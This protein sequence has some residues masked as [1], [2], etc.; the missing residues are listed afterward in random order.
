M[1]YLSH[2]FFSTRTPMSLTG[3]LMG[4]FKPD[5][6]LRAKLPAEVLLGIDNHRLVD[7]ATDKFLP[8]KE[9]RPLFSQERRRY[10][11][12]I[13]DI[14]FDYFLIKH[15]QRFGQVEFDT[16]IDECY[17]GL[18]QCMHWMPPRMHYVV[19]KMRE[20]NWLTSYQTMSGIGETIDHV[21]KRIRFENNMAGAI[22]EVE[23]NYLKIEEVFLELFAHLQEQVELADLEK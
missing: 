21:S 3:N 16:F 11:G 14:A 15:W 23:D 1:N 19:S 17:G 4:D 10:A 5:A 20:H 7:R 13:T 22:V 8:V 2:L 18:G 12:V 6:E 9:L